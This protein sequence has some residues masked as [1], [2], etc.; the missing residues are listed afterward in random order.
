MIETVAGFGGTIARERV[1]KAD[2]VAAG[3]REGGS[4]LS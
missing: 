2:S 3:G 4:E 1:G